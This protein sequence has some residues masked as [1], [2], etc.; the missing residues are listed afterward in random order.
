MEPRSQADD[1]GAR[2]V[3]GDI[4]H[5]STQHHGCGMGE[6][7]ATIDVRDMQCAQALAQVSLAVKRA[8]SGATLEILSNS[9]DVTRDLLVWANELHH[10]IT[11]QGARGGDTWLQLTKHGT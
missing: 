9:Q 10:A 5:T 8:A 6:P 4:P 3:R 11:G 1:C 7:A 2:I